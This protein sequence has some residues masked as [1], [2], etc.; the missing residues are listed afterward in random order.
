ME[1]SI[2]QPAQNKTSVR[3][4]L[5][6]LKALGACEFANVRIEEKSEELHVTTWANYKQ[7]KKRD[8][9]MQLEG[10]AISLEALKTE[11]AEFQTYSEGLKVRYVLRAIQLRRSDTRILAY[12]VNG[13]IKRISR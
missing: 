6:D 8:V 1:E 4:A 9:R 10:L 5:A 11:F 3:F 12:M 7:M 13:K 2:N